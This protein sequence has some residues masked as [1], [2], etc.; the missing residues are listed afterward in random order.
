MSSP[1]TCPLKATA[2]QGE[3]ARLMA[4]DPASSEYAIGQHM[5][6]ARNRFGKCD[7]ETCALWDEECGLCSLATLGAALDGANGKVAG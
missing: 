1:Y 4:N 5:G 3:F 6:T 2:F 7:E